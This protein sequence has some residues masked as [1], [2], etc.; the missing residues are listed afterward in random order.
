MG[1]QMF[2]HPTLT[3]IRY[4]FYWVISF[5]LDLDKEV[6]LANIKHLN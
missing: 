4:F 1:F 6:F 5:S 2:V 3:E